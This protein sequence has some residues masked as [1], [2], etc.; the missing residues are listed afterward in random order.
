M[1]NVRRYSRVKRLFKWNIG[2]QETNH[3]IQGNDNVVTN[4]DSNKPG[5]ETLLR[6]AGSQ[7]GKVLQGGTDLVVAPAK[8]LAHMQ[9]NW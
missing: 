6:K 8:W 2:G 5:E 7:V 3:L 4:G 1:F 9:D